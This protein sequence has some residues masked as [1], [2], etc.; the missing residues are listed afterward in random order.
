MTLTVKVSSWAG[1]TLTYDS[2]WILGYLQLSEHTPQNPVNS[3]AARDVL[4][5][6]PRGSHTA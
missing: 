1:A 2:M 6:Y 3:L 4:N 5:V